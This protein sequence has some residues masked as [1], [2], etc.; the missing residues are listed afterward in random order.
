MGPNFVDGTGG[1][2]GQALPARTNFGGGLGEREA[3]RSLPQ[4]GAG[5]ARPEFS[6]EARKTGEFGSFNLWLPNSSPEPAAASACRLSLPTGVHK[7]FMNCLTLRGRD[8]V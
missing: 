8:V 1:R 4:L 2:W 6:G 7:L 3:E 5:S